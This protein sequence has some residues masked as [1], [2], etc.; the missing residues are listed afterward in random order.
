MRRPLRSL[1]ALQAARYLGGLSPSRARAIGVSLQRLRDLIT[2]EGQIA[3]EQRQEP[4]LRDERAIER[5][6]A[7]HDDRQHVRLVQAPR[8][9]RG[10]YFLGQVSAVERLNGQQVDQPPPDVDVQQEE[11]QIIC[12]ADKHKMK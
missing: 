1:R 12:L 10:E 11:H 7:G 2:V 6:R 4:I 5:H 9:P 3:K 8:A